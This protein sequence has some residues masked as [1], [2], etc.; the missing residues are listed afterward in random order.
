MKRRA[1]PAV[2]PVVRQAVGRRPG[3]TGFL[4]GVAVTTAVAVLVATVLPRINRPDDRREPGTLVILSGT[5]DGSGGQ[6]QALIDKWNAL[7]NRPRAEIRSVAG[8]TDAVRNEMVAGAQA[9][10]RGID[11]YNLDVTLM[12]EFVEFGY[13][14]PLD[15]GRVDLAGFLEE[16]LDTCRRDGTLWALPFNTNAG[17]LYHR[18]DLLGGA[19]PPT[20]WPGVENAVERVFADPP[21]GV[22]SGSLVAG[23]TG[24]F[25]D[26]E[27]LLV[28]VFE[29]IWA[30]GGD[31]VDDDNNV[32]IDTPEAWE[33]LI[34]LAR[35]LK[36]GNPQMIL[37]DSVRFKEDEATQAF[38]DGRVVFMRNWPVAYRRLGGGEAGKSA[39]P[40]GVSRLPG[41]SVLGGQNLAVAAGSDQ[42]V[43]AQEL[44]E[45]LTD[46]LSQQLLF[47]RGGFAATREIVYHDQEI[48]KTYG[49]ANTLLAAIGQTRTRPD[50]PYYAQFSRTFRA[51]VL[52]ALA[53]DGRLPPGFADRLT[54]AL[55]GVQRD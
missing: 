37:P 33:G 2:W 17:L 49:Y 5:D 4:A 31:V 23:Y 44:I 29:A 12:A 20:S 8:G 1:R 38:G 15:E 13:L 51:G 50:T 30:A 32:V 53:N 6:R 47:E 54:D 41:D 10:G 16:P 19:E 3:L 43:A 9:G 24:Q 28:N 42:P 21:T 25:E 26:Y 52:A 7:G 48:K 46:P 22:D 35:G 45:Y 40:F 36:P 27:G 11:I 34:R 39:V 14:R 18:T 55:R